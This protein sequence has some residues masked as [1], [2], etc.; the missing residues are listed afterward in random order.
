[1]IKRK[2]GLIPFVSIL[3][4]LLAGGSACSS[5]RKTVKTRPSPAA[6]AKSGAALG[7]EEARKPAESVPSVDRET[8][9]LDEAVEKNGSPDKEEAAALLEDALSTCQEAQKAIE[10][11]E[12]EAALAKL[13]DAYKLI[14]RAQTRPD[15]D[16]CQEK[17]D[18]RLLIAQKIQQLYA[19]HLKPAGRANGSIPLVENRWVQA[20]IQSFQT[21]E[22]A[23]F[24][25]AYKR[26]GVYRPMIL[27]ELK[28]GGLPDLLSWV[29]IIESGFKPRA[30]SRARALG[31]WQFIRSTGYLYGLKQD[32]YVD[33]R[34]DPV[35][36]TRAAVR[37]LTELHDLFGD[38]TTALASYNCGG[39]RVQNVIRAQKI[40][41]LDNF[42][43]LFNNLP[44][45]TARFVPRII[46]IALIIENP[47]KYGF[48]LPEPDG[49]VP[50]E[51]VDIAQPVKLA[52]LAA[53]L[54][55]DSQALTVLNP[56]LRHDSTPDYAYSLRVPAGCGERIAAALQVLP[57][58]IPPDVVYGWYSV[59]SG[60]TLGAIARRYRTSAE[61]IMRLN[62]IKNPR[63]LRI[64]QKLKIPGKG[65][66]SEPD[67]GSSPASRPQAKAAQSPSVTSVSYV[68]K[69]G[70]TL[71]ALARQF[72]TTIDRIKTDN[73]LGG[74]DLSVG[75][76][77]V[78][79]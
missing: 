51:I 22:R 32:K 61:A 13:D 23:Y 57:R 73:R 11:G 70:D 1:M 55:V 48:T 71:F 24:L 64:G 49:P 72:S 53:S 63:G 10:N 4:A 33:E 34:M 69:D 79:R 66:P 35:K 30:L 56:E 19:S 9:R 44:Y 17:N 68:V 7:S 29:P 20:E 15:Q 78:I 50:F 28:K 39:L 37:F 46:A 41:Y 52:S 12:I 21:R 58:Y 75:Q 16:L 62:G 74:D 47:A 65:D 43:D 25:D 54:G 31:M 60:D 14:L 2:N 36:A 18:L 8:G 27:E 59:R 77:L 26:S 42:W 38:W 67:P 45:E 40:D 3:I 5:G 6:G 76:T